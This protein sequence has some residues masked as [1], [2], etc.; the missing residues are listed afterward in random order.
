MPRQGDVS[1]DRACRASDCGLAAGRGDNL[2]EW[3]VNGGCAICGGKPDPEHGM[4][5]PDGI[6]PAVIPFCGA[7]CRYKA[8]HMFDELLPGGLRRLEKMIREAE[9]KN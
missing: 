8:D 6:S 1:A 2:N 4:E 5:D 7:E 3:Q 9:R